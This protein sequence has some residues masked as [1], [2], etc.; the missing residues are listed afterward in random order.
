MV[1]GT[2]LS[3]FKRKS[4]VKKKSIAVFDFD[5]VIYNGH[6]FFGWCDYLVKMDIITNSTYDRVRQEL[7][8]YKAKQQNYQQAANNMLNIVA[9]DL[10]GK[11]SVKVQDVTV[12]FFD[13]NTDK[14]YPYFKKILPVLGQ[15][16][17]IWLATNNPQFVADVI[18]DRFGL[19]GHISTVYEVVNSVLTG[20]VINSLT[21]G[22]KL[23]ADLIQKYPG[24]SIAVGDSIND[25]DML[26]VAKNSICIN[27]SED[28]TE[29]AQKK[30]WKI[31]NEETIEKEIL[32]IVKIV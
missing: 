15:S 29:L 12:K 3:S 14:F 30:M 21:D 26:E 28:L 10:I 9:R 22:K 5:N 16:H 24:Q 32:R 23:A 19:S 13:E 7:K 11:K 8:S 2:I 4:G 27:P 31:V 20:K 6:S 18:K 1:F 25:V 17:E